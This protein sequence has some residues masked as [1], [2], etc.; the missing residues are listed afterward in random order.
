[1]HKLTV[2]IDGKAIQTNSVMI[3]LSDDENEPCFI[4]VAGFGD[5]SSKK[6]KELT[7]KS[8]GLE[9]GCLS[10]DRFNAL[11]TTLKRPLTTTGA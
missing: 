2:Y 4:T 11:K 6:L 10:S 5:R 7:V 8:S 1:M 3:A 9:L